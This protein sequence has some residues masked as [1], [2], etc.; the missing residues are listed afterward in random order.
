MTKRIGRNDACPCGSGRKHKACCAAR[1]GEVDRVVLALRQSEDA[2]VAAVSR[3]ARARYGVELLAMAWADFVGADEP[4]PPDG[5]M[6]ELE[7]TF[8]PW[9]VCNWIPAAQWSSAADAPGGA[10]PSLPWQPLA[11]EY[12]HATAAGVPAAVAEFLLAACAEPFSFFVVEAARP[13]RSLTL[14]DLMSDRTVTVIERLGSTAP[15]GS[16]LFSRVVTRGEVAIQFGCA[17][18]VIPS[19]R[20]L[21]L[22]DLRDALSP[23][24]RMS[25]EAQHAAADELRDA[26]WRLVDELYHPTLPELSNH[27]GD[28]LQFVTLRYALDCAPAEAF[29]ALRDLAGDMAEACSQEAERDDA[30][31]I[32]EVSL[33]WIRVDDAPHR[34]QGAGVTIRSSRLSAGGGPADFVPSTTLATLRITPGCMVVEVNS[35]RRA[36]AARREVATRLGARARFEGAERQDPR[37]MLAERRDRP[38]SAEEDRAAAESRRLAQLPEVQAH[39]KA[40]IDAHYASWVDTPLP[41][42]HGQT[43]RAAVATAA[44]RERVEVLVCHIEQGAA[45]GDAPAPDVAALRRRLGLTR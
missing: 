31:E 21:E 27:D 20:H 44:G 19:Q 33:S 11:L 39:L 5:E 18:V 16:I 2:A 1:E 35:E 34:P 38:R 6:P 30:G 7:T 8:L 28:P 45:H 41:A 15:P 26:Y 29:A 24:G 40:M 9:M 13:G 12:L 42:L 32:A 4:E 10:A 3:F 14:R 25:R 37:A 17:P 43:P 23:E 22:L 36:E